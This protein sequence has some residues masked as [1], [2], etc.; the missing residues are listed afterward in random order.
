MNT[1]ITQT[2]GH[3]LHVSNTTYIIVFIV[4]FV[5]FNIFGLVIQGRLLGSFFGMVLTVVNLVL[6]FI[7]FWV[8]LI[9]FAIC[10]IEFGSYFI[11]GVPEE[12]PAENPQKPP[13]IT[14]AFDKSQFKRK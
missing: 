10:F 5:F 8:A 7:P 4:F 1:A 14:G 3:Q 9:G 2:F 12:K 6:S 13:P 11:R